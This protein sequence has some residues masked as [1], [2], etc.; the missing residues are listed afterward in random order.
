M[1]SQPPWGAADSLGPSALP[2]AAAARD[3]GRVLSIP[4][5]VDAQATAARHKVELVSRPGLFLVRTM[6]AGAYIGI[7]V[8][9]MATAGGPLVVAGS[10]FAPLDQGGWTTV[11]PSATAFPGLAT[12]NALTL[13]EI[14]SIPQ[15]FAAAARRADEAGFDVVELHAAHGYL[16]HQFLSPLSNERDDEYGGSLENRARLLVETTDAVRA[17]ARS[18]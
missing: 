4:D 2:P 13:D 12:P 6:L 11:G 16:L 9:I 5:T 1:R 3:D 7:G 14:R 15:A 18:R 10:P 8:L 17:R